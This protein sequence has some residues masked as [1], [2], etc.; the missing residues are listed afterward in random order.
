MNMEQQKE[1]YLVWRNKCFEKNLP[2]F[3]RIHHKFHT[4]FKGNVPRQSW[5]SVWAMT[6]CKTLGKY[7]SGDNKTHYSLWHVPT[8]SQASLS[9]AA[10]LPSCRSSQALLHQLRNLPDGTGNWT[11]QWLEATETDCLLYQYVYMSVSWCKY[12]PTRE[13]NRD[14]ILH[15]SHRLSCLVWNPV[16]CFKT[17]KSTHYQ[18]T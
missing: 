14:T 12:G 1:W 16:F 17:I 2:Y 5:A 8:P 7:K 3:H 11:E 10:D 15:P 4:D 18:N 13:G 9:H 6:Q